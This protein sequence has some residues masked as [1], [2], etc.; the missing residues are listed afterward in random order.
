MLALDLRFFAIADYYLK[1]DV[2]SFKSQLSEA[3]ELRNSLFLRYEKGEAIDDSYVSML[4]YK[5]L[6]NALAA[7]NRDVA[8]RLALNMGGREV[9]ERKYDHPFDYVMGYTLRA[10]VLN[11]LNEM[12]RWLPKLVVACEKY[13]MRD[14]AG[15]AQ[16]FQGILEKNSLLANEGFQSIIRGHLR[17]T[18]ANRI[19]ANTADQILCVWGI[20]MA[21]LAIS[22]QLQIAA[23]PPLLPGELIQ[24]T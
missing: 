20:G 1:H 21:N 5:S 6:F 16:V 7:N 3:A 10:F 2:E 11:E 23:I 4:S 14:F 22:H 17:Q 8:K 18:K 13:K 12:E 24:M 15:Y 19:F 9:L